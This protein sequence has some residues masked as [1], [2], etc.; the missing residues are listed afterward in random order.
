MIARKCQKVERAEVH[1]ICVKHLCACVCVCTKNHR[2]VLLI[3]KT[4]S[5]V[6]QT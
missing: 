1:T 3:R 6:N 2:F 4:I 5:A